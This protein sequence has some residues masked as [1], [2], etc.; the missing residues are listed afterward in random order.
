MSR[1]GI[2]LDCVRNARSAL[3]ERGEK[4]TP[5]TIRNELGNT[6]SYTTIMEHLKTLMSEETP[7]TAK[8]IEIPKEI[9]EKIGTYVAKLWDE[10]VRLAYSDIEMIRKAS[11]ERIESM[12][13]QLENAI[14]AI[15]MLEK[16][17]SHYQAKAIEQEKEIEGL[18]KI[19]IEYEVRI[20]H[21]IQEEN[22]VTSRLEST[23]SR[24]SEVA[25]LLSDKNNNQAR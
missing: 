22:G 20:A 2:T 24:L 21:Y 14:D 6:G 13:V 11:N 16:D 10:A 15:Q 8:E 7:I 4:I 12:G 19:K 1:R 17:L 25:S 5:T 3:E 9:S 23:V 18:K